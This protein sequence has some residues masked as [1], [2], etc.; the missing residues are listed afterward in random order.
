VLGISF[1]EIETL[2]G[3]A[4]DDTLQGPNTTVWFILS[5]ADGGNVSGA[6]INFSGIE[7][8]RWWNAEDWFILLP[9]PTTFTSLNGGGGGD[10]LF[11]TPGDDTFVLTGLDAG[12]INGRCLRPSKTYMVII[13]RRPV[14][15]PWIIHPTTRP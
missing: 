9:A 6:G 15:I 13:L 3:G 5:G 11:G 1:S 7:K 8:P 12:T 4:G 14:R 10:R 2:Q